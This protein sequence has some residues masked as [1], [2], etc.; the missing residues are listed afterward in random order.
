MELINFII[1]I[2]RWIFYKLRSLLEFLIEKFL[3]INI[4]E[5]LIVINT[6]AA[7][8]AIV[9][10]VA[11][12]YIFNRDFMV[13]NPLSVYLI[14]I[15]CVMNVTIFFPV[16]TSFVIRLVLNGYFYFWVLYMHYGQGIIK[17]KYTLQSGY[18]VNI[19]VPMIYVLLSFVSYIWE[20]RR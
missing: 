19:A 18:Y 20:K 15:V 5:K 9:M 11:S 10:P 7:F 4:F 8:F 2:F 6:V 3:E 17:T 16:L 14:G 13:N 1:D 12:H